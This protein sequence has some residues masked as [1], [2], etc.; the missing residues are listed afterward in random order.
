MSQLKFLE[1]H[2]SDQVFAVDVLAVQE[3]SNP[4]ETTPIAEVSPYVLGI[5]LF[6]GRPLAVIDLRKRFNVEG[7]GRGRL[8]VLK[9]GEDSPALV[10]DDIV[11]IRDVDQEALKRPEKVYRGLKQRYIESLYERDGQVVVVLR[12][13]ELLKSQERIILRKALKKASSEVLSKG[14]N[15]RTESKKSS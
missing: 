3:V 5:A 1:F 13:P 8:I 11:G 7:S 10:V 4:L 15:E 9:P 6:R 2:V 12:V 14:K